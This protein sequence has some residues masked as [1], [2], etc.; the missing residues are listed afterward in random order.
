MLSKSKKQPLHNRS[1]EYNPLHIT[2]ENGNTEIAKKLLSQF[3]HL[4]LL[5]AGKRQLSPLHIAC[6]KGDIKMVQ[7]ILDT[8]HLLIQSEDE[9]SLTLDYK[10][11]LGHTPLYYACVRD[12]TAIVKLLIEFQAKHSDKEILDVNAAEPSQSTPLH[13][14]VQSG[15]IDTLKTLLHVKSINLN[16]KAKPAEKTQKHCIHILEKNLHGR[17]IP[18]PEDMDEGGGCISPST[19]AIP[20][21][22]IT[23]EPTSPYSTSVPVDSFF[24][25]PT[26]RKG[27]TGGRLQASG[28]FH[29]SD[30]HR[31][32]RQKKRTALTGMPKHPKKAPSGRSRGTTDL[33]GTIGIFETEYGRLV[34]SPVG[35]SRNKSFDQFLITPLAEA[36]AFG[37][38]EIVKLLLHHGARDHDGF[39]C[40]LSSFI[41]LPDLAQLVLAHHCTVVEEEKESRGVADTAARLQLQW[42]SK[43]LMSLDG[44]WFSNASEYF[45]VQG[46][47]EDVDSDTGYC[48]RM[49]LSQM[50][51]QRI[52]SMAKYNG[53]NIRVVH[54]QQNHLQSIPLEMFR[55][56][57]V[58]EIDLSHNE[59]TEL[60]EYMSGW[61]CVQL[62]ELT[63]SHNQLVTLPTSVWALPALRKLVA[64]DNKL[65]TLLE[66]R[67]RYE[68]DMLSKSLEH[69]DLSNNDLIK[70]PSLLFLL[71]LLKKVILQHN[72]L[73]SLPDTV[74][75]SATLQELMI[76]HNHLTY[77]PKCDPNESRF[78]ESSLKPPPIVQRSNRAPSAIVEVR[79]R[80]ESSLNKSDRPQT[81]VRGVRPLTV[82]QDISLPDV[83][84][85]SYEYSSLKKL[86]IA[87]NRLQRFPVGLPCFAPNLTELDVSNNSF[88]D[89]DIRFIPQFTIK[90]TAQSCKM[91]RFG[92]VLTRYSKVLKS[93]LH[94]E[95][96]GHPCQHRS[97]HCL[98]NLTNLKLSGNRLKHFQ[99]LFYLPL[100]SG[101]V[102]VDVEANF[103]P[104]NIDL[105]YPALEALELSS[106][107][108]RG[109]FNPNIGH[110]CH[111]KQ[112]QLDAN[113]ELQE[114][115]MEFAHLR[116][117]RQLTELKRNNLP[118][119]TDPPQ[120][121]L[122][123]QVSVNHLLTFMRSR[124]KK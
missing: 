108:L 4:V 5:Q 62:K 29:S 114:L 41:Q 24:T 1:N 92:I 103:A 16:A 106:N 39:A 59:C 90:F 72:K 58:E 34:V 63:L 66:E 50:Q 12:R 75:S 31:S 104:T 46:E 64:T 23:P 18:V 45:P 68:E 48:S 93:C 102:E 118:K 9:L 70:L 52:S 80:L 84:V 14:A 87:D 28:D 78:T 116:K 124:L 25:P 71:P 27:H 21:R 54:L 60:P 36:C 53:S 51:E 86:S 96:F 17:V 119:L 56:P 94:D 85:G 76:N 97:H 69:I 82:K 120:E 77:L 22:S 122:N 20:I 123:E 38:T 43:K 79:P 47:M 113:L 88:K 115:P 61:K 33:R 26:S 117:T 6:S 83:G 65:E 19:E 7:L 15:S 44:S 99:I 91:E 121:Y 3:P 35:S 81:S 13:A 10:D 49:G 55:L 112:I 111:L 74:W 109:K 30:V 11:N 67:G 40:R 98:P 73:E 100:D 37:N 57:N 8:V 110:Q 105:L 107:N 42:G 2:C 95:T 89:I 101:D 32:P